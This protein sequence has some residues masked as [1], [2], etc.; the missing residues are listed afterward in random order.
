MRSE[1][2][3]FPGGAFEKGADRSFVSLVRRQ[4]CQPPG[5]G[6]RFGL[7]PG[8]EDRLDLAGLG[9]GFGKSPQPADSRFGVGRSPP[10][11]QS[12]DSGF[13]VAAGGHRRDIFGGLIQLGQSAVAR[14]LLQEA[15]PQVG[16]GYGLEHLHRSRQIAQGQ[17]PGGGGQVPG[18]D[19]AGG[20]TERKRDHALRIALSPAVHQ[21]QP[22][23][24]LFFPFRQAGHPIRGGG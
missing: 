24:I 10:G 6:R 5:R 16:I 17:L 7:S 23:L 19:L 14:G 8:L 2:R 3:I 20:Q 4:M 9:V 13:L 18:P 21:G 1:F 12:C 11:K 15:L 22:R